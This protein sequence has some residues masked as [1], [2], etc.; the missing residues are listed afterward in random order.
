[1]ALMDNVYR[2]HLDITYNNATAATNAATALNSALAAN[3]RAETV[4][5]VSAVVT[6]LIVG[7]SESEAQTLR[8]ALNS[9]WSGQT[10]T[11]GKA[12]V[13]RSPDLD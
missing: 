2:V 1:M 11:G 3:G 8:L 10:R 6:L 7:L 5:R 13:V 12:S 9:A 4:T